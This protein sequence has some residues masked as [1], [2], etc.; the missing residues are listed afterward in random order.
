MALVLVT[1]WNVPSP[2]K[3][4]VLLAV[5]PPN[6]PEVT[7]PVK[8][9]AGILVKL[10]AFTAGNVAGKRASAIVPVKLAAGRPV[11]FAPEPEN[12]VAVTLPVTLAIPAMVT[13]EPPPIGLILLT[14]SILM[15]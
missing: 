15:S 2:R 5:P 6:L 11:K 13:V 12:V 14:F 9:P 7:I 10:E 1:V 3:K 4:V 8:L